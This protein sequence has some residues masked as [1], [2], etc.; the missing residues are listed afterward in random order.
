MVLEALKVQN[1]RELAQALV[2]TLFT[3]LDEALREQGAGDMGISRRMK[4]MAGAFYGRLSAYGEAREEEALA[5]A[6]LRNVF[7][8]EVAWIEHAARLAKYAE[9][10]RARLAHSRLTEG[11][12]D[13]VPV[14]RND[15]DEQS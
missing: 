5:A 2:D 15:R 7:R 11:E 1:E 12:A 14:P 10:A 6:L 4:A 13:F 8:G 9:A 3:R